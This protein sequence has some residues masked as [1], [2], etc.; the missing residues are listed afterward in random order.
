MSGPQQRP[1]RDPAPASTW[2]R[3]RWSFKRMFVTNFARLRSSRSESRCLQGRGKPRVRGGRSETRRFLGRSGWA[4]L[5]AVGSGEHC[6]A[7][8][9]RGIRTLAHRGVSQPLCPPPSARTARARPSRVLTGLEA[10]RQ[11]TRPRLLPPTLLWPLP[12]L[13]VQLMSHSCP[14]PPRRGESVK[15]RQTFRPG[16]NV[17]SCI[18]PCSRSG[19]ISPVHTASAN[20][21]C[22]DLTGHLTHQHR[23]WQDA[24]RGQ[25]QD[26]GTITRRPARPV[27]LPVT[28]N[29]P[30]G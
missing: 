6:T 5:Q 19:F 14:A 29:L 21:T 27:F 26:N 25:R 24:L 18:D 22:Q 13:S 12:L 9:V 28:Q 30:G 11:P 20:S 4:G 1:R 2:G 3:P 7:G 10:L 17:P 15:T 16:G 23:A 8:A